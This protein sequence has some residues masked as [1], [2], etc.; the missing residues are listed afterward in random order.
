MSDLH[1]S[2]YYTPNNKMSPPLLY[3]IGPIC[4]LTMIHNSYSR[5]IG[6]HNSILKTLN[7]MSFNPLF[8]IQTQGDTNYFF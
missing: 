8:R 2:M 6:Q 4:N 7:A 5:D 1:T 3:K